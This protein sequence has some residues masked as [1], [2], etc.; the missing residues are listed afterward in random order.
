MTVVL[1][2]DSD[3]VFPIGTPLYKGFRV[4][5]K[6]PLHSLEHFYVSDDKSVAQKY[7]TRSLCTYV[8][9]K[10]IKLLNLTSRNIKALYS[11]F[12][13]EN[14][15]VV[16]FATGINTSVAQQENLL[17]KLIL[18]KRIPSYL[19]THVRTHY[20]LKTSCT[21]T[22]CRISVHEI[23]K[24]FSTILCKKFLSLHGYDGYYAHQLKSLKN[25]AFH[26]EIMICDANELVKHKVPPLFAKGLPSQRC[27][28]GY[29]RNKKTGQCE[30]KAAPVAKPIQAAP[31]KRCPNGFLKSKKTGQCEPRAS[32]VAKPVQAAPSK[33][34]PNG[35]RRN[36][37]TGLCELK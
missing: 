24:L 3:K 21:E 18:Q 35:F 8:T 6:G 36:K 29:T 15:N 30:P 26:S 31:S 37:K 9:H 14:L 5:I 25:T 11:Y 33:R 7:A 10:P 4:C 34:C 32:P 12:T 22:E 19:S 23:D 17:N 28:N 1:L 27:P 20:N 16:K 13:Q 2:P